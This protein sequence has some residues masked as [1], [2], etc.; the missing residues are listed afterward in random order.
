M[1][2]FSNIQIKKA[3]KEGHII[4]VPFND[5]HITEASLD[6]TLGYYYYKT[7]IKN[8]HTVY[9]P[10]DSQD[11]DRYF[12]GPYRALEH[13]KS[14]SLHGYKLQKNIPDNHPV[15]V[16]KPGERIL[17]HSHEFFGIKPPGASMIK[18]RSSWAR[19]GLA[20]CFDAGWIDPGYVNRITLQI[21]NLNKY[22]SIILPVGERIAQ[23]VFF[24]TGKIEG[25]YG[26]GDTVFSGKYQQGTDLKII[27]QTW[28]PNQMLPKAFKDIRTMPEKIEGVPY[29]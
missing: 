13:R 19:N 9:N 4:C 6:I 26:A 2:V 17:A 10:F 1:G 24:E 20:V 18:S 16:I 23:I 7:E 5:K 27:M 28:S 15:I 8:G 21:Y 14:A 25:A 12:D 22:E 3:I 29:D 11:V